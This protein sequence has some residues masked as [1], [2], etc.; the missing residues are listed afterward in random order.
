MSYFVLHGYVSATYKVVALLLLHGCVH[1]V[2]QERSKYSSTVNRCCVSQDRGCMTLCC[3]RLYLLLRLLASQKRINVSAVPVTPLVI[4]PPL[5]SH[6]AY[7]GF[8][9][10]CGQYK[11]QDNWHHEQ[12]AE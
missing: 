4:F 6:L 3:V 7:P 11:K 12:D 5:S 2:S 8:S 9:K 1:W 10:S